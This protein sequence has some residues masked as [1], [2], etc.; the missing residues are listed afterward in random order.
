METN[1][2]GSA[3]GKPV[4]LTVTRGPAYEPR[5]LSEAYQMATY[6]AKSGFLGEV[7]SPEKALLI[8][9]TGSELGIPATTALRT[10][11]IVKGKPVLAADL[12]KAMCLSRKDVCEHFRLV[13]SD[14][15]AATYSAKRINDDAV[16]MTFSME[17]AAKAK[18]KDRGADKGE[19]MYDKYPALM[20]RHRCVAMVAREVFPDIVL[21]I[22][23]EEER[24]EIIGTVV[25]QADVQASSDFDERVSKFRAQLDAVETKDQLAFFRDSVKADPSGKEIASMLAG[26]YTAK[27]TALKDA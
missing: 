18:L 8:M 27:T 1:T 7:N 26:E 6:F 16:V 13:K 15:K 20:L 2:N 12:M 21:G 11:S 19:A 25:E 9:A 22:Y 10:V 5:S 23:C 3:E 14:D 24:E 17:D 4:A